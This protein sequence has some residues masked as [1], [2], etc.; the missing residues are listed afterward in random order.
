VT[1]TTPA[2]VGDRLP[3]A[4]DSAELMLK[5][6]MTKAGFYKLHA[7]GKFDRFLLPNAIGKRR[8]SGRLVQ[9]YLDGNEPVSPRL[10]MAG[11]HD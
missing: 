7:A 10:R 4:M 5:L 1:D 11:R 8:F 9:A 6:G 3:A 2:L